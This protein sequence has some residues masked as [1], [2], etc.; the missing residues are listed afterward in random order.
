MTVNSRIVLRYWANGIY[1]RYKK[2]H[3][4][5]TNKCRTDV[6]PKTR[7][8]SLTLLDLSPAFLILGIG[9]S[10]SVLSF[11]LEIIFARLIGQKTK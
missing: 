6:Q 1:S 10:L 5:A 3:F 4:Q 7:I 9:T 11:L 2:A 8:G